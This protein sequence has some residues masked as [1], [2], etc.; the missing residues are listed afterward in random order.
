MLMDPVNEHILID[1]VHAP[2]VKVGVNGPLPSVRKFPVVRNDQISA[3][4]VLSSVRVCRGCKY[5]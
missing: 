5:E 4:S 1:P 2:T 3:Y